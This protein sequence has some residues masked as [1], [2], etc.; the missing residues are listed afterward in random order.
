M[1]I[2]MILNVINGLGKFIFFKD[3][4]NPVKIDIKSAAGGEGGELGSK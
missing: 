4:L 2:L 3:A 1:L